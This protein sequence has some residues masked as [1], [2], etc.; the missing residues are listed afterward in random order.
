MSEKKQGDKLN[1]NPK[2]KLIVARWIKKNPSISDYEISKRLG[3]EF[4]FK[5][6]D[7]SVKSWRDNFYS[8]VVK[9]LEESDNI[10]E[11]PVIADPLTEDKLKNV[12]E[13]NKLIQDLKEIKD[14]IKEVIDSKTRVQSDGTKVAYFDED[15]MKMYYNC[16]SSL[17][18][19]VKEKNRVVGNI[20]PYSIARAT[21]D[22]SIEVFM[23]VLGTIEIDIGRLKMEM[24]DFNEK[25]KEKYSI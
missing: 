16:I 17:Y 21:L 19:M 4:G 10:L 22:G 23:S 11:D 14:K 7:P 6:S 13:L 9:E 25:L 18:D 8:D 3:S 12:D 2:I 20:S 5:I 24:G 15:L 1:K